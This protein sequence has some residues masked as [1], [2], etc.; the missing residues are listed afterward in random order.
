M[1]LRREDAM[2]IA[3]LTLVAFF[4]VASA[5]P[6][7]A[8]YATFMNKPKELGARVSTVMTF[9]SGPHI[10]CKGRCSDGAAFEHWECPGSIVDTAC[11]LVC[12]PIP[13]P[14]CRSF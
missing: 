12:R 3:S 8:E 7:V 9:S 4:A 13:R 11:A 2:R 6:A 10:F 14:G 1:N 5:V